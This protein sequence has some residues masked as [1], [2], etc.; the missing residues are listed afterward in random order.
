MHVVIQIIFVSYLSNSLKFNESFK[1]LFVTIK[2]KFI[3]LKYLN[4]GIKFFPL[5]LLVYANCWDT[6]MALIT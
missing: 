1:K 5:S 4:N 3:S 2:G 6:I